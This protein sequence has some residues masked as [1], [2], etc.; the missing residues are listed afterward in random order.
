MVLLFGLLRVC[1]GSSGFA[2][3]WGVL[4]GTCGAVLVIMM[5][6]DACDCVF[7]GLDLFR[8][9]SCGCVVPVL[10][11]SVGVFACVGVVALADCLFWYL[12]V[13]LRLVCLRLICY[14]VC[15]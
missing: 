9:C 7:C 2:C 14:Y 8:V 13:C 11:V 12:V 3:G 4:L 5:L 10:G 1:A 15:V 6:V